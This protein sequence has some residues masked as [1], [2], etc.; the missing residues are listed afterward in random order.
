M[1]VNLHWAV[2][3]FLDRLTKSSATL[4]LLLAS[5]EVILFFSLGAYFIK[6]IKH[7]FSGKF[8][9]HLWGASS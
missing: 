6:R 7:H 9:N 1:P 3:Y 8:L 2:K 4:V 5:G